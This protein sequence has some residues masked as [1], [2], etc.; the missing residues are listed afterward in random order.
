VKL[1]NFQ[2]KIREHLKDKI[3]E[4]ETNS[5]NKNINSLMFVKMII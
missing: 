4:P 3:N 2:E 5:K 1:T